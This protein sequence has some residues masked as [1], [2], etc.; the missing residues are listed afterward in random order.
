VDGPARGW[1]VCAAMMPLR[2]AAAEPQQHTHVADRG[3]WLPLRRALPHTPGRSRAWEWV[4]TQA[5][6]GLVAALC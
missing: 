4:C 3:R 2:A 1:A 6:T 5:V